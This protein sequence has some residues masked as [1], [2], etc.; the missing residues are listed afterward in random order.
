MIKKFGLVTVGVT[1]GLLAAAP[2]ASAHESAGD[3]QESGNCS[4]VG[5]T[6]EGATGG[7]ANGEIAGIGGAAV[8]GIGGNNALNIADCSDFLNHN[9]NGNEVGSHNTLGHAEVP[10]L[11]KLPAAPDAGALPKVPSAPQLSAP[12]VAAPGI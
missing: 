3:H 7:D 9:L 5:G 8:G 11:P 2:F 4:F 10:S 1:A 12:G 6:G